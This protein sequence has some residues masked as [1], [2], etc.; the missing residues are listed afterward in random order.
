MWQYVNKTN[1]FNPKLLL[2]VGVEGPY[3]ITCF[4]LQKTE[5]AYKL[6][7][8]TVSAYELVSW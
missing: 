3:E 2:Q 8:L 6:L 4:R 7:A 5:V 1:K